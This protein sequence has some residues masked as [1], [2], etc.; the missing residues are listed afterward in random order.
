M[1]F[2][3]PQKGNPHGLTVMQHTFPRTSITRFAESDGRVS[4]LHIPTKKQL[5]LRPVD[6]L[7]CAKRVWDQSAEEGF[8]KKIEDAFQS[9]ADAIVDGRV[10]RIGMFEESI[11]NDFFALWNIRAHK[12]LHPIADQALNGIVALERDLT[13]DQQEIL[14]KGHVLFI[15]PDLKMPGRQIAGI[16]IRMN[17]DMLRKQ[18]VGAQ[19]GI[20]TA[21]E[22]EFLVPDISSGIRIVPITPKICLF[23]KSGNRVISCSEVT[24]INRAAVASSV[25]YFFARDFAKCPL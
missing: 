17:L 19:W 3:K 9:L 11:V 18:L 22:G 6:Q 25:E 20:L 23:S 5:S 2:E 4:V 7:F 8:M 14:E 10:K 21:C 13:K 12:K 24:E 1:S 15:R 16:K